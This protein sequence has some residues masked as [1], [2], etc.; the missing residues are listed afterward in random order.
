VH[1]SII[2]KDGRLAVIQRINAYSF[3]G[4]FLLYAK[5]MNIVW[6]PFSINDR[7]Y[8]SIF[9]VINRL[10]WFTCYI[11]GI[12]AIIVC[13]VRHLRHH[14]QRDHHADFIVKFL[15]LSLCWYYLNLIVFH[16]LLNE[17]WYKRGTFWYKIRLKWNLL[18]IIVF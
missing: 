14:F 7:I 12:I 11:I 9:Y 2:C 1:K 3:L 16:H 15:L 18:H 10:S 17:L 8:S 6:A 4:I 5:F 13:L